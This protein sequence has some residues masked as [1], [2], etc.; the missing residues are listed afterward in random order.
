MFRAP[1]DSFHAADRPAY[2]DQLLSED[3][4][5]RTG[6]FDPQKVRPGAQVKP[7]AQQEQQQGGGGQGRPPQPPGQPKAAQG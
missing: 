6:Y 7:V 3:S 2:V 1:F 4:L 5:R